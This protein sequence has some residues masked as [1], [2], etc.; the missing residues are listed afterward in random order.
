[1][2]TNRK[3]WL[4]DVG[5]SRL[6]C[7]LLHAPGIRGEVFAVGHEQPNSIAELLRHMGPPGLKDEV[8]LAS[9]ASTERTAALT[10]ALQDAGLYVQRIRTQPRCGKLRI[11]YP[12]PAQLGVDRFLALLAASERDDGPWLVVSAGSALTLDLLAVD[13]AHLG[14]M[15]AP[16]PSHMR[17]ALA[18]NFA[19]LDV[20]EGRVHDFADNTADAIATGAHTALLG[21]VEHSLRKA[22]ERLQATPT[23]LLGGG[24]AEL[25]AG[26][27]HSRILNVPALVLD[28]MTFYV[29]DS[30]R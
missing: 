19:Q 23:L 11:A 13:G 7:A 14:G 16:M 20:P 5:N 15:I 29:R 24:N 8:W 9:V 27:D 18:R 30:E 2:N 26:M 21:A 17:Q 10:D 1:M 4:I 3:R 28:G 22:R 6:K 25:L 12:E